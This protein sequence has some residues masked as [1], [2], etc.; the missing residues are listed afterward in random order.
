MKK[1]WQAFKTFVALG[2]AYRVQLLIWFI[3]DTLQYLIFPFIWITIMA[4]N[5]LTSLGGYT[6]RDFIIYYIIA[7]IINTFGSS[8]VSYPL[9]EE[10]KDGKLSGS[11]LKPVNYLLLQTLDEITHKIVKTVF[12]GPFFILGYVI[13]HHAFEGFSLSGLTV[14]IFLIALSGSFFFSHALEMLVGLSA[15]WLTENKA[16]TQVNWLVQSIFSGELAPLPL[17]PGLIQTAAVWLPFRYLFYFPAQ[18]FLQR[19]T[20]AEIEHGLLELGIWL[21][22]LYGLILYLWKRGLRHYS[23]TGL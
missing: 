13:F 7:G 23:G 21:L 4:S 12:L 20:L 16:L 19:L 8:H 9:E 2:I 5:Q 11:L 14:A 1:Y 18:I 22:L 6:A 10:I 15:F 3:S 17:L